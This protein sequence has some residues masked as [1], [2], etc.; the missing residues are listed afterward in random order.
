MNIHKICFIGSG[1]WATALA[2]VVAQNGYETIIYGICKEEIDE[3]N[4]YHTN[5]KYFSENIKIKESIR[6]TLSLDEALENANILVLAIP[7][8]AIHDMLI[9]INGKIKNKPIIVNV[10]KGFD[11]DT[12]KTI[13]QI[14]RECLDYDKIQGLVSLIGPSF[15]EEVIQ[16]QYTTIASV[17][18]DIEMATIVQKTFSNAYFRVYTNTDE[19][20]SEYC[21]ALKNV[22]AIA[23]GILSGLGYEANPHAALIT[24]GIAEISRF[25]QLMG[26]KEK[27]C[28]GLTG[29]GDLTLTCSSTKSRNYM[30]GVQIGT[31]KSIEKFYQENKKTVEGIYACKI[32]YEIAQSNH[33]Y[34]PIISSI[35]HVLY[36]H[37]DPEDE[38]KTMMN[39]SLKEE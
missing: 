1:A 24:R 3:I 33:I 35:Y 23:S 4:A 12:K 32:A 17:S 20:G 15:A 26:G 36:E 14:I 37:A 34:A 13:L 6:A 31:T 38:I 21:A 39:Y 19:I 30:A 7:S 29:I 28:M 8:F 9:K 18:K 22:I 16:N 5:R 27:T 25:A 10:A 2:N 11:H